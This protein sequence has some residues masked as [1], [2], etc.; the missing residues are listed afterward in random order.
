MSGLC[1]HTWPHIGCPSARERPGAGAASICPELSCMFPIMSFKATL[2]LGILWRTQRRWTEGSLSS[3]GDRPIPTHASF[4][5]ILAA[6]KARTEDSYLLSDMLMCASENC[7][8]L[9][10]LGRAWGCK[11]GLLG[12]VIPKPSSGQ[13]PVPK[14]PSSRTPVS[15]LICISGGAGRS[16]A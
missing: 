2:F 9:L 14:A 8:N 12:E 6:V 7:T 13:I 10:R 16:K 4:F 1:W 3:L 5:L 15:P 11:P